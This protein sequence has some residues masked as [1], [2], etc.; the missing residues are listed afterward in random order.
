MAKTVEEAVV[1]K[2]FRVHVP[3]ER[4]FSVF[5]E[6]WRCVA[7]GAPYRRQA[8]SVDLRGASGGGRWLKRDGRGEGVR[9][10][11]V[12]AWDTAA[13]GGRSRGNL[14]P[15]WKF[16]PD[17]AKASDVAIR[18]TSEG[19]SATLMNWSIAGLSGMAKVMS[20]FA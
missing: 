6:R 11:T 2:A 7:A 3:I 16:N 5:V 4:A 15:D 12:R 18:F 13:A 17:L 20:S 9:L 8:L 19:A 1:R 10:G 14:G